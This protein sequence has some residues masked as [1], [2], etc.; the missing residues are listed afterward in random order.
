VARVALVALLL[1]PVALRLQPDTQDSSRD[2]W[3]IGPFVKLE[4]PVLC[5]NAQLTF[6]CPIKGTDVKWAEL[7]VYNPAAIVKDGKVWLLFRAND[8]MW[9]WEPDPTKQVSEYF[10]DRTGLA[11]SSDGRVFTALPQPVLYPDH[12]FMKDLVW[13]GGLWETRVVEDERRTYYFYYNTYNGK[14]T[15]LSVATSADLIHWKKHGPIFAKAVPLNNNGSGSVVWRLEKCGRRVAAKI[16][17][18]Y[19]MYFD[20]QAR[21]ATSENLIDWK[22]VGKQLWGYR[23]GYFDSASGEPGTAMLT[24]KGI[25]FIYVSKNHA[26]GPAHGADPTIPPGTWSLGQALLDRNDPARLLHRADRPFLVLEYE[27]EM[28][29]TTPDTTVMHEGLVYFK[30]EWLLYYG[31]GDKYVGLAV[32]KPRKAK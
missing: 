15:R 26:W 8:R 1:I 7:G 22:P 25:L 11:Y 10:T 18:K 20:H 28:Q 3:W 30:G 24:A 23:R 19:W 17:G 4:K 9:K 13:E 27:W 5:P 32:F 29:G 6:R 21:L 2:T 12:D 14:T 16:K 31:G